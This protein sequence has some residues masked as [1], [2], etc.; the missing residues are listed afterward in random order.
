M[1][2]AS[3]KCKC[4]CKQTV[5]ARARHKGIK[6][7]LFVNNTH[8]QAYFRTK[9]A[10]RRALPKLTDGYLY[11]ARSREDLQLQLRTPAK[12]DISS[13][14]IEHLIAQARA[15]IKYRRATMQIP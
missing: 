10:R 1:K 5:P 14:E 8:A 7:R 15:D 2:Q 11:H 9:R 4:G 13:A 3:L 12:G 6:Q